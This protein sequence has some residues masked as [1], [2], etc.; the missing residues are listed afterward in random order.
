LSGGGDE[1]QK[2]YEEKQSIG[3][4]ETRSWHRGGGKKQGREGKADLVLESKISSDNREILMQRYAWLTWATTAGGGGGGGGWGGGGGGGG[5]GGKKSRWPEQKQKLR[6][7]E[8]L[9]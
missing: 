2:L 3:T 8:N 7:I 4:E 1:P 6:Q 5:G 9:F